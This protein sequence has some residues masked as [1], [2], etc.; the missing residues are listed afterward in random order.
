M[1]PPKLEERVTPCYLR[2]GI[3]RKHY[4]KRTIWF[5]WSWQETRKCDI[6]LLPADDSTKHVLIE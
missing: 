4:L 1:I 5:T 2:L 6:D 3:K